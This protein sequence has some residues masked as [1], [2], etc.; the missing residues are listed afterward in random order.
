MSK[1]WYELG[2]FTVFDVE[3]TGMSPA[4]DRMVEIAAVRIETDGEISRWQTLLN[5]GC[6]I[7]YAATRVHRITDEM[8][9][10]AP[11]FSDAGFEFLDFACDSTLVAHNARFDLGFLQ[12]SLARH[13]LELWRG[14]TM[15]TI[16]LMKQAYAG[17]PSYSLQ[18]LRQAFQLDD[19]DGQQAHR[20][21]ADVEWTIQILQIA[22]TALMKTCR[23]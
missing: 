1:I 4:R 8:V 9:S 20:A 6:L 11:S 7:P 10:D 5:P 2:P 14:K 12:E 18:N 21:A 13:G 17:L 19:Y 16:R 3:T 23:S 22:L 15:D